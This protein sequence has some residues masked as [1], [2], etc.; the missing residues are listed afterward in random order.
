[1]VS[2]SVKYRFL[3][4]C[5]YEPPSYT[6]TKKQGQIVHKTALEKYIRKGK[7]TEEG[8]SQIVETDKEI[9]QREE[10]QKEKSHREEID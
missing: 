8:K 10:T 3:R 1:M 6:Y 4:H 7:M 2:G 9:L 5:E